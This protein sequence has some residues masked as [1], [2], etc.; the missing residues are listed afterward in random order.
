MEKKK[1]IIGYVITAHAIISWGVS[2]EPD[3]WSFDMDD[4]NA[5]LFRKKMM[6]L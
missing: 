3:N 4:L 2:L 1:L 5:I 6:P